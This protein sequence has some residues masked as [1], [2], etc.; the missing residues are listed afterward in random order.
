VKRSTASALF[1]ILLLAITMRLLPLL[2]HLHWGSDFGEYY[3]L[4]RAIVTDGVLPS[5]YGGW[6]VTYP[7]FPGLY[8]VNG[9]FVFA[10]ASPDLAATILVPILSAFAV[11]PVFL[12]AARVTGDDLAALLGAAFVSVIMF[13]AYTT[14]H[15][16]PASLG[17]LLLLGAFVMF[18]GLPRNPRLFAPLV[19]TGLAVVVTHHLATYVL[20]LAVVSALVLRA[21]LDPRLTTRSIRR[22]LA[23]L[24]VLLAAAVAFWALYARS[25]WSLIVENSP[26]PA[27]ALVLV[28]VLLLALAPATILIRRRLTWRYRPRARSARS[29]A[30]V[31]GLAVAT[32]FVTVG[33]AAAG[34]VWGTTIRLEWGY[35]LPFIPTF[36]FLSLAAAGR[37]VLDFSREGIAVSACCVGLVLSV[38]FGALVAPEVI[39]PY[40]HLE[41]LAIPVAVMVGAGARWLALGVGRRAQLGAVAAVGLLVAGSALAAYPPPAAMGGFQE[42]ISSRSV[43]AALWVRTHATGLVAGDHR[44]SSVLFG[45]GGVDGT[46]NREVGFWHTTDAA[47]AMAAMQQVRLSNR[48]A[49]VDWVAIDADLR[50]GLQTSPFAPALPLAPAEEAK[51]FAPPFQKVFDS[52]Y[53]QV[54]FVNWGL[55]P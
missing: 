37:R 53:A 12:I 43:E 50:A 28:P 51:F 22:E 24:A 47:T 15:A 35:L 54:Y 23:F 42:G 13:H 40:R 52:G 21:I 27:I 48:T 32:C 16:I 17:E 14:S 36:L 9:A 20:V 1:A 39:I 10:G 19:L 34:S 7:Q 6:G 33:N 3:A 46:W 30:L 25:F 2:Q 31:F 5:Q 41:Y 11:L 45:F 26:F 29:A 44:L 38:G 55:A 49:R 18:L 4:T 8:V